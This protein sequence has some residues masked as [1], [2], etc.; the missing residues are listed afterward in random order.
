MSDNKNFKQEDDAHSEAKAEQLEEQYVLSDNSTPAQADVGAN[1]FDDYLCSYEYF[2]YYNS[3]KSV[4]PK[5]PKPLYNPII[6]YLK[7][8]F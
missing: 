3:I 5:L 8:S 4:N 1:F 7:E 2:L 6:N